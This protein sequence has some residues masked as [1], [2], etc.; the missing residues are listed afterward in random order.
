M[1]VAGDLRLVARRYRLGSVIGRGGMGVVWRAWDELLQREVAA[2]EIVWPAQL[3]EAERAAARHR[4]LAEARLAARLRH[5]NVVGIY[6]I[7]DD[8]GRPWIIMELLPYRSLH[9]VLRQDGP[10]PPAHAA[11]LGLGILAALRAAHAKGIV[12]RDVKPGN[13]IIAPGGR[14]VL[15]DF[16]IAR[17]AGSP[18]AGDPLAGSPSYI[19]P[20]RAR[21]EAGPAAD[22]WGLG[23]VLY[24]AVEGRPPFPRR[25]P[26]AGLTATVADEL[27]PAT[28]AGPLWPAIRALLR[29]D[30][31]RR[32]SPVE[33]ERM[34]RAVI[35]DGNL[36]RQ[37]PGAPGLTPPRRRVPNP[38]AGSRRRS[39]WRSHRFLA[40]VAATLA[41]T[42][43][44]TTA[45]A[46]PLSDPPRQSPAGFSAGP[47]ASGPSST[48][49]T[50]GSTTPSGGPASPPAVSAPD[51]RT[52]ASSGP[53]AHGRGHKHGKLPPG[54]YSL[55]NSARLSVSMPQGG[56]PSAHQHHRHPQPARQ[57]QSGDV[58][59]G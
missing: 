13:I 17:A 44:A 15:T 42:A 8:D 5:P 11:E 6:D 30:P 22:L 40:V 16:G 32:P 41:V 50:P 26:L 53:G 4:A 23:A 19:A 49:R 43:A 38:G 31:G 36:R 18:P 24:A 35:R 14:A 28:H 21:G 45:G 29:R 37:P 46:L 7:A 51:A 2:K 33:A 54:Q 48:G 52:V 25:D 1:D 12:H 39:Q 20:E 3:S 58:V 10:L 56:P 59:P 9:E 34:L 55:T 27:E 47:P 57:H